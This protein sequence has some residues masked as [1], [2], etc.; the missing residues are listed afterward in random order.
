MRIPLM[1]IVI[2]A[3][4]S[5]YMK[6]LLQY[7]INMRG[8]DDKIEVIV[9]ENP[10]K[11][12][13]MAKIINLFNGNNIKHLESTAGANRARNV[14]INA[15]QSDKIALLDDDCFPEQGW[16][17]ALL[18][19]YCIYPRCNVFGGAVL[20]RYL[21]PRPRWFVGYLR[22]LVGYLYWDEHCIDVSW[23]CTPVDAGLLSANLSFLKSSWERVGGFEEYLGQ[24]DGHRPEESCAD[25][26]SFINKCGILCNNH[27]ITKMY[28]GKMLAWHQIPIERMTIEY[29][30]K[31]ANGHG[32]GGAETILHT[33]KFD[34][35]YIE[36]IILE[37][38]I[39]QYLSVLNQQDLNVIRLQIA[40]EESTRI[41]IK[42]V[43]L[44][45]SAYHNS[46]IDTLIKSG[47][48]SYE[49]EY[50]TSELF[51]IGEKYD[52]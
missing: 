3:Y 40:H 2:P 8:F 49:D 38:L 17:Q 1:S 21:A 10:S 41:F 16:L 22:D 43:I 34:D 6:D 5:I 52:Y 25:E 48:K 35:E 14:G 23:R 31:K 44:C 13:A 37:H 45:R 24:Q 19:A 47:R 39:P 30:L 36:D 29:L 18:G 46:F 50:N 28:I 27:H 42:N 51:F 20:H 32:K 12:D 15:A 9:V 7:V 26:I 33:K 11:T 4:R